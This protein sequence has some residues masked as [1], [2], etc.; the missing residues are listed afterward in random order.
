[1][2]YKVL[3]II[4]FLANVLYNVAMILACRTFQLRHA[5]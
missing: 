2:K 3:S 5:I 4:A 1:M